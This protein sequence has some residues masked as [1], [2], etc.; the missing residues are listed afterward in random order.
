MFVSIAGVL[1]ELSVSIISV[2]IILVA[3]CLLIGMICSYVAYERHKNQ[4]VAAA[5]RARQ[6]RQV[7]IPM[8]AG[9]PHRNDPMPPRYR[10]TDESL[11]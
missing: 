10:E 3:G 2:V 7:I 5:V 1:L 11:E 6:A 4:R 9:V 8:M